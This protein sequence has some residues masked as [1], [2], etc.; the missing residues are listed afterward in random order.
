MIPPSMPRGKCAAASSPHADALDALTARINALLDAGE[1]HPFRGAAALNTTLPT[2]LP[3]ADLLGLVIRL[4][5]ARAAAT[6]EANNGPRG[7]EY[8]CLDYQ[9]IKTIKTIPDYLRAAVAAGEVGVEF[10]EESKTECPAFGFDPDSNFRRWLAT[11]LG[12]RKD[13]PEWHTPLFALV[14]VLR[15]RE[16]FIHLDDAEAWERSNGL[17]S[18]LASSDG[19]DVPDPW[20][21]FLGVSADNAEAEFR[22][23]WDRIRCPYLWNPL[24]EALRRADAEPLPIGKKSYARSYIRFVSLCA[25]AQVAFGAKPVGLPQERLAKPCMLNL[26]QR[27]ISRYIASAVKD[28]F[29]RRVEEPECAGGKGKGRCATYVVDLSHWPHLERQSAPGTDG[30]FRG[31]AAPRAEKAAKAPDAAEEVA[32]AYRRLVRSGNTCPGEVGPIRV[33]LNRGVPVG[34]L[35]RSVE[36]YAAECARN[37]TAPKFRI[38]MMTFFGSREATWERFPED[39]GRGGN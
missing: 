35:L 11:A 33:L 1:P 26:S 7:E 38:G 24:E 34:A 32:S 10:Q 37:R 27:N 2:P 17:L 31:E 39:A 23:L 12:R 18:R 36:L 30:L 21:A 8:V 25:Y 22:N 3:T 15:G 16:D 6:P 5:G 14:Q 13:S 28:G 19:R 9:T 4:A 20:L 29:L